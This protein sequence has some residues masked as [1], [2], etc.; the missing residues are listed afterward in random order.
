MSDAVLTGSNGSTRA[1]SIVVDED[2]EQKSDEDNSEAD[3]VR[4]ILQITKDGPEKI[5]PSNHRI[6]SLGNL[7]RLQHF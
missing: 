2:D 5:V 3:T 7:L 1:S 4:M 6:C